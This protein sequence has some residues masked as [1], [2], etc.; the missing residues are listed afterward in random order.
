[1]EEEV[2]QA[3]TAFLTFSQVLIRILQ[4]APVHSLLRKSGTK[5]HSYELPKMYRTEDYFSASNR[6]NALQSVVQEK[7]TTKESERL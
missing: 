3:E 4:G 7:S 6:A 5:N 2:T 1:M